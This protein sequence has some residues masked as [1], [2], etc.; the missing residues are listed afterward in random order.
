M[1]KLD[2]LNKSLARIINK[3]ITHHVILM[4]GCKRMLSLL[5][6]ELL[7]RYGIY[8]YECRILEY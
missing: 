4:N 8:F 5:I 6:I 7:Y 2:D 1:L 3:H